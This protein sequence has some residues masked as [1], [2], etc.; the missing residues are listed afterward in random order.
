M[1][2]MEDLTRT[3]V[4]IECACLENAIQNGDVQWEGASSV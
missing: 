4:M 2:E 1:D 3:R